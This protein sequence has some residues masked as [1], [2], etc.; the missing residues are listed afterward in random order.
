MDQQPPTGQGQGEKPNPPPGEMPPNGSG[1][2]SQDTQQFKTLEDALKA[3]EALT[4][5]KTALTSKNRTLSQENAERRKAAEALEA[6][7]AKAEAEK[8]KAAGDL[9]KLLELEAGKVTA[10]KQELDDLKAKEAK[11]ARLDL[12]RKAAT[13]AGFAAEELELIAARLQGETAE[14]LAAD[15]KALY[16]L[17]GPPARNAN[18]DGRRGGREPS[19][20]ELGK[21]SQ[22]QNAATGIYGI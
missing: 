8:A 1:T 15:A 3:I 4:A 16:A 2:T 6:E 11:R 19:T 7:K 20:E 10:L 5:D 21:R 9:Q 12:A 17:K 22:G 18:P 14:D 13:D